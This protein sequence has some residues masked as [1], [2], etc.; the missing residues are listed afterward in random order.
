MNFRKTSSLL[1]I[2]V[3]SV[4]ILSHACRVEAARVLANADQLETYS[5][6]YERLK[7]KLNVASPNGKGGPSSGGAGH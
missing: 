1:I 7:L 6:I 5:S 3:I 4:A 2:F